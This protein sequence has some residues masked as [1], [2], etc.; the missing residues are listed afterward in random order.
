MNI[1][2]PFLFVLWSVAAWV[3]ILWI[4][5]VLGLAAGRH[6][7]KAARWAREWGPMHMI[8]AWYRVRPTLIEFGAA[9]TF[10]FVLDRFGVG[11]GTDSWQTPWIVLSIFPPPA[12]AT[13]QRHAGS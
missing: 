6:A 1:G 9:W 8:C 3:S 7:V 2:D 12:G 10:A 5:A 4:C 13:T 11:G